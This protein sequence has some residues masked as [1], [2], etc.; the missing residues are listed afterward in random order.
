M[1]L[2]RG[3]RFTGAV[4][5]PRLMMPLTQGH[6]TKASQSSRQPSHWPRLSL[7]GDRCHL[8]PLTLPFSSQLQ[9]GQAAGVGGR[10]RLLP[11]RPSPLGHPGTRGFSAVD[12][13]TKARVERT[14]SGSH[15][16]PVQGVCP[17]GFKTPW[18]I[19]SIACSLTCIFHCPPHLCSS[20]LSLLSQAWSPC[21]FFLLLT[22][23]PIQPFA[24]PLGSTFY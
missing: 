18:V 17:S 12:A 3:G 11:T 10:A 16:A 9:P 13:D 4:A 5:Q 15:R 21:Y 1:P 2:G 19:H 24:N 20:M 14:S 23:R 6:S 7:V 22:A 8:S